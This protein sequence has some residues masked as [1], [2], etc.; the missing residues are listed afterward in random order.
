MFLDP[1]RIRGPKLV[2]T[3]AQPNPPQTPND[4]Q[5]RTITTNNHTSKQM[6]NLLFDP[7]GPSCLAG[8]G[9]AALDAPA[10]EVFPAVGHDARVPDGV[11]L[12]PDEGLAEGL[13]HAL[14]EVVEPDLDLPACEQTRWKRE[15]RDEMRPGGR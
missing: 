1:H 7:H 9:A 13:G 8:A 2:D 6:S 3:P 4:T 15:E 14:R 10:V 12:L 5:E 11:D